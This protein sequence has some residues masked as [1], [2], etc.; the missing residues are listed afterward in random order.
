MRNEVTMTAMRPHGP[1][2]LE[3][4]PPSWRGELVV[5]DLWASWR[6]AA[7]DAAPHR[8]LA[9]QAVIAPMGACVVD[10]EGQR[11]GATVILIDPLVR[12]ALL[13]I[14]EAQILFVEQGAI[15]AP[16]V[17]PLLESIRAAR[18]TIAI[19]GPPEAGFW[20]AWL[21]GEARSS[22]WPPPGSE[23]LADLI[24]RLAPLGLL[25][26][27]TAAS[28]FGLSSSRFRHRFSESFGLPFRRY[29]LWRR[30]RLAAVAM[31]QGAD[32]TD[33]AHAAGFADQSHYARTLR[34]M[35]GVTAGQALSKPRLAP[36]SRLS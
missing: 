18:D 15:G 21:D 28:A 14:V 19:I 24:D 7:G 16:A 29:V 3:D 2:P 31:M 1:D 34:A 8:H 32:A 12:H 20:R 22:P 33:A 11:H 35:F 9:A 13:P 25:R 36:E 26:L 17:A 27:E 23:R 10:G 6:G 30:L 4:E 5:G